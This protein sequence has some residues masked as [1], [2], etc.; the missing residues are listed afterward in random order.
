MIEHSWYAWL[1]R[2]ARATTRRNRIFLRDSA[3]DFWGDPELVLHEYFHVL[4]QWQTHR[5]T[6][7]RYLIESARRGYWNNCYEIEARR[8]ATQHRQQLQELLSRGRRQHA[9][10]C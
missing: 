8:F 1:H 4:C 9:T 6:I 7:W 10:R 2:G 3:G 5:L